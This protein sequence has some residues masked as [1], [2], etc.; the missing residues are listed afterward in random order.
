MI[1]AALMIAVLPMA[2]G[3]C[4][5]GLANPLKVTA[6]Q[7]ASENIGEMTGRDNNVD[8]EACGPEQTRTAVSGQ[9]SWQTGRADNSK[10]L[11]PCCIGG[12]R[13]EIITSV[14]SF[15]LSKLVP[16]LVLATETAVPNDMK[17]APYHIPIMPPPRLL[18]VKTTILRL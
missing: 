6:V 4:F 13:T 10:G 3:F 7:A 12:S 1:A 16:T 17:S 15:E 8:M 14:Q 11:L 18:A 9:K 2:G 5:Q